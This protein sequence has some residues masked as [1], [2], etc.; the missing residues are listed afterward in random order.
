MSTLKI[1]RPVSPV[2]TPIFYAASEGIRFALDV[3]DRG[4]DYAIK[5]EAIRVSERFVIPSISDCLWQLV[6]SKMDLGYAYTPFG[7]LAELAFKKTM[8]EIMTKGLQALEER[9]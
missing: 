1:V 4:M 9:T 6:S 2:S 7:R 3:K 5:H 8:N